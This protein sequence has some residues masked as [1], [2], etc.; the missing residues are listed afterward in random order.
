MG[1]GCLATSHLHWQDPQA[2][3]STHKTFQ[4]LCPGG[5]VGVP[6]PTPSFH[7]PI[8]ADNYMHVVAIR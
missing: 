4:F 3:A 2:V 8:L 5:R 6:V 1:D 7:Q